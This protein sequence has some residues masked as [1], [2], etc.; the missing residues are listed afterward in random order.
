MLL[1]QEASYPAAGLCWAYLLFLYIISITII[2]TM[3]GTNV[4]PLFLPWCSAQTEEWKW[5]RSRARTRKWNLGRIESCWLFRHC[6]RRLKSI[7]ITTSP[8]HHRT[9]MSVEQCCY[10]SS[11]TISP[12]HSL[13]DNSWYEDN[14]PKTDR[15]SQIGARA[16]VYKREKKKDR[17]T[18]TA[19]TT[20]TK[21]RD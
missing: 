16:Y 19:T 7:Q 17:T 3:K 10:H 20:A 4:R 9:L 14:Y 6:S 1:G 12:F 21:C 15:R 5:T 2:I 8:L 18:S 13:L 11:V